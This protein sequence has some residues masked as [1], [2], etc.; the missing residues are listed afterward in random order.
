LAW[1]ILHDGTEAVGL[2]GFGVVASTD[3]VD[4]YIAR[5]T[6]TVSEV[7]K[8]LDPVAD[9]LVVVAV[10]VALVAREAFPLWAA[11]LII[12][13]DVALL[14]VGAVALWRWGIRI[15]V[16]RIGKAATLLLMLGV[17]FVASGAFDL[18]LGR[19]L[20]ATGWV[21]YAVGIVLSY[22]AAALYALDLRRELRGRSRSSNGRG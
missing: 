22:A 9:R 6:G 14:L 11:L 15:E 10:L 12:V 20:G 7:G 18:P 21:A 16:R 13:R 5:R 4:G 1:A 19:L 2:I 3:W 8:I 17:P